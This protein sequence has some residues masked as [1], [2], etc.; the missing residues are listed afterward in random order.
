MKNQNS[1]NSKNRFPERPNEG[2]DFLREWQRR[3]L[4]LPFSEGSSGPE[5]V[6]AL[7]YCFGTEEWITSHFPFFLSALREVWR[8]CGMLKTVFVANIPAK[9]L[10]GLRERHP[11]WVDIRIIDTLVAE[12]FPDDINSMSLDMD[13][14]L[15][16]HFETDY[17]LIFQDDGF[18]L[19]PGLER[20]LGRYDYYGSPL[21][22]MN[23]VQ[24]LK[25]TFTGVWPS[26]GGFSLRSR[27]CCEL[28]N[29]IFRER[30]AG[31][32]YSRRFCEDIFYSAF[33]PRRHKNY[34]RNITI[35][36]FTHSRHFSFE[37]FNKD[38]DLKPRSPCPFGFHSSRGFAYLYRNHILPSGLVFPDLAPPP[39]S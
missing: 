30:Y 23:F 32:S 19:R 18:P 39:Q 22:S 28:A 4:A 1:P 5:N 20:F 36:P 35:A 11:R 9:A 6:T 31:R 25:G 24:F 17:V 3:R 26:N 34:R 7:C 12:P 14:N 27:K 33:L 29:R 2:R 21:R 15:A 8:C 16:D 13:A 10:M 38:N 37:G